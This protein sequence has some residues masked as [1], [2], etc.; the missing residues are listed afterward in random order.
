[1]NAMPPL[2]VV[3]I[4]QSP[5]S[6]LTGELAAY[7]PAGTTLCERGAIDGLTPSAIAALAPDADEDTL[8]S[9]LRD[10]EPVL[11]DRHRL[12]PRL[13]EA[14]SWLEQQ[15]AQA[16]LLVCTGSFPPLR[17]GRP[18]FDAERLLVSGVCAVA[19]GSGQLGVVVP[20]PAQQDVVSRRWQQALGTP[21][22]VD[23]A[24]PYSR[25]AA[26]AISTAA[27]RLSR[28]GASLAVLDCMGY[29]EAHREAAAACAGIPVLLARSMVGRLTGEL[30]C[31]S[32]GR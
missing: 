13:E 12:V 26:D 10:G 4:G 29:T 21:V 30:L 32:T 27:T 25:G 15:G 19:H 16:S 2:G 24:D 28:R 9:R 22:M 17:H 18:L 7:L 20:L 3:T 11:L 1:M 23:H 6:D 31:A 14:I 8:T 5:R